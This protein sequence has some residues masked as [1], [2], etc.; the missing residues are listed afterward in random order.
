MADTLPA[1]TLIAVDSMEIK[2]QFFGP[3]GAPEKAF[4]KVSVFST[5]SSRQGTYEVKASY[6][7]NSGAGSFTLPA[8]VNE[9]MPVLRKGLAPATFIVGFYNNDTTFYDLYQIKGAREQIEMK[10][11]KAYS[12]E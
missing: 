3:S 4:F 8:A 10:Y 9:T 5:A 1:G 6:G 2:D 7:P 12:F 11:T